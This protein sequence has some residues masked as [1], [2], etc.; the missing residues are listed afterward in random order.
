MAAYLAARASVGRTVDLKDVHRL[1][2]ANETLNETRQRLPYGRGNVACDVDATEG[3]NRWRIKATRALAEKL[4]RDKKVRGNDVAR[5]AI[6]GIAAAIAYG[7][8]NCREYAGIS[9]MLHLGR[10][11]KGEAASFV[12]AEGVDHLWTEAH[13]EGQPEE[14]IVI[15]GWSEGPPVLAPDGA[16]SKAPS[17]SKIRHKLAGRELSAALR[18]QIERVGLDL[19]QTLGN[20]GLQSLLAEVT[21]PPFT[22]AWLKAWWSP[23]NYWTSMSVF[24]EEF[25]SRA[26][27]RLQPRDLLAEIAA[28]GAARALQQPIWM[29]KIDVPR[30]LDVANY[31]MRER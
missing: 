16:F 1:R 8:G 15:D 6:H 26:R 23:P 28:A 18:S 9:W 27:E 4:D 14:A 3:R 11:E 31:L 22:M 30:I 5:R 13:P 25:A 10:L 20:V 2:V 12:E 17:A 19:R 7:V 21:P 24:D 29:L